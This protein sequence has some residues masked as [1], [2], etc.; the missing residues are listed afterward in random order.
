V[1]S[2]PIP[3]DAST[4]FAQSEQLATVVGSTLTAPLLTLPP[5]V[6]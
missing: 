2:G 4:F 5:E 6:T 1:R 3:T